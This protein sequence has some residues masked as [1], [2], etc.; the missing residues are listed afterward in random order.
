MPNNNVALDIMEFIEQNILPKYTAFD[1]AHNLSH[2]NS[3]ITRS[4]TLARR[5]G[6]N[7]DMCYVIAAYHDLGLEG[8]RAIHHLTSG[9][10]IAT[11]VRLRRWFSPD[12][13]PRM[14]HEASTER[15]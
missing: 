13:Q 4:I 9:K 3:V 1:K 5:I 14:R 2:V 7:L 10:I 15:L 11:D 8:P 12:H 6:A